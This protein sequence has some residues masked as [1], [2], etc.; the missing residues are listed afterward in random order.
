MQK[1]TDDVHNGLAAG[2]VSR[3]SSQEKIVMAN[4]ALHS[5]GDI[6]EDFR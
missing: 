2:W 3:T 5:L 1:A 6:D 4:H